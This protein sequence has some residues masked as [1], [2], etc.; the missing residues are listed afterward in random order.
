MTKDSPTFREVLCL[1]EDERDKWFN[2]MDKELTGLNEIDCF[3]VVDRA[4]AAGREIVPSKWALKKKS[5]P[6][7]SLIKYKSRLTI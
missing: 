6:D 3:H 5:H 1:S 2:S 7:G 4:A